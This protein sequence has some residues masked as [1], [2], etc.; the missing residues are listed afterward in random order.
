MDRSKIKFLPL[1]K[2]DRLYLS[3][4]IIFA[5]LAAGTFVIFLILLEFPEGTISPDGPGYVSVTEYFKG[6]D[7]ELFKRRVS[8]PIIPILALPFSFFLDT[9]LSF[10]VVNAI[11]FVFLEQLHSLGNNNK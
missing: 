1:D 7:V 3:M 6:E 4:S 10:I 8:R 11:L 9:Q 5:I 2:S